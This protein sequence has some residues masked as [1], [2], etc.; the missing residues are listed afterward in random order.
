MKE[1]IK[2]AVLKNEQKMI[3]ALNYINENPETGFKEVKTSK[4]MAEEFEKL[5]YNLVFAENITGFYTVLDTNKPGPEVLIFGELD[6]VICPTHPNADKTTGAVHSCGHSAQSATM[7]GIASA[8]K[9][10]GVIDGLCGKIK[11]C[12]VPAEELLELEYRA[13]L[14]KNGVIKYFGGKQEFL[15]R[16][17]F[18]TTDLC[19]MVHTDSGLR[20][21]VNKGL[22][23]C[24]SVGCITKSITYKGVAAHAGAS[25]WRGVNALYAANCG[26][27]AVN[28]IRETFSESNYIRV[29]PI[30]TNGGAMVNAIPETAT[31]ESYVRGATFEAMLEANKKVNRALIGGALSLGA[32]IEILDVPGYAPINTDQTL[33]DVMAQAGDEAYGEGA[34]IV[35]SYTGTGSS[36]IGDVSC[37]M[38]TVHAYAPGAVGT[39]HGNNFY[40]NDTSL[41]LTKNAIWQLLTLCKLL[42]NDAKLAKEV[43]KNK[44]VAFN[45]AKEYL[46]YIDTIFSSGNRIEYGED[47]ATVKL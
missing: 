10:P 4:Y 15:H 12:L 29:H 36:D 17:Y 7:L 21:S 41:A 9:E 38:P 42:E 47:T 19:F 40:I 23:G 3:D 39:F 35:R 37:I 30:I 31:V 16:G 11:L 6:S 14:K 22:N 13:Q 5:G 27:N 46:D 33:A 25:P 34:T 32:N 43:I 28:A 2:K 1:L 8:L 18:D 20:P 24:S 26:I 44:K 45:S